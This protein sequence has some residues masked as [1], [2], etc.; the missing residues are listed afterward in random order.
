[1]TLRER[2]ARMRLRVRNRSGAALGGRRSASAA[3]LEL[4]RSGV[5]PL[6][7][8]RRASA[9]DPLSV[10]VLIPEFRRGSGGHA[11]IAH[12]LRGLRDR[13]H[14]LSLWL[15]ESDGRHDDEPEE[16]VERRFAEFFALPNIDLHTDFGR[17]DGAEVVLATGWQTVASSL[18]LPGVEGR[19]YLV[20]D[21]EPDFFGVSAEA[22]W[23]QSSYRQGIHCI[24]ASPWLAALLRERYGAHASHFDLA[25]DHSLY[26]PVQAQRR[27]DLVVFYARPT[28]PR[29]ATPLG[30]LALEE[31]ARRRT[32]IEIVTYGEV[33]PVPV[34]FRSRHLGVL[35]WQQLRELYAGATLGMALSLTNPSLVPLEMM[36]CGLPVVELESESN[37]ATFGREGPLTLAQ[38]DPLAL[39]DAIERLLDE[40]ERRGRL[41]AA[42]VDLVAGRSWELAA[43]QVEAGLREALMGAAP[44]STDG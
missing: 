6:A 11:T 40:P 35:G 21:H 1:M 42:G 2:A 23:A 36:A 44:A 43:E 3:V 41:G 34:P 30:L 10:A 27:E 14:R 16:E 33:A 15:I 24:A 39:C 25:I 13:G 12:L 26:R 18:V 28:T 22:L 9:D 5:A 38:A 4:A 20:Q 7:P 8:A 29:R 37:L 32:R 17:W 31:L 19:A